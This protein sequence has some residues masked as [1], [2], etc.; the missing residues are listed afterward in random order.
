MH[1]Q[2]LKAG[3]KI[4]GKHYKVKVGWVGNLAKIWEHIVWTQLIW[5][6]TV[7]MQCERYSRHNTTK[8]KQCHIDEVCDCVLAK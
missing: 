3:Q 1:K 8:T 2:L 6:Y 5:S 7:E 4:S